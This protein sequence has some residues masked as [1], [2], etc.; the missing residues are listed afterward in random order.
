MHFA[1]MAERGLSADRINQIAKDN[2]ID[3]TKMQAD[4]KDNKLEKQLEDTLDLAA[5][6]P[7]LT[8]TPFFI[9]NDKFVP[10]ASSAALQQTLDEALKS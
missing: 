4:M 3:V 5:R 7:A 10:G 8:G 1:L 2:G 9:I 6:I